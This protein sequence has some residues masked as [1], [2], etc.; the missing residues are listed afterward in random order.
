VDSGRGQGMAFR[1]GA[2]TV[3]LEAATILR[4]GTVRKLTPMEVRL[5]AYLSSRPGRIVP[6]QELLEQVWGYRPGVQTRT[7]DATVSRVREKLE[8]E[9]S[10]PEHL[11][12]VYG[13]GIKLAGVMAERDVRPRPVG[14]FFGRQHER[15][16]LVAA[17]SSAEGPVTVTGPPGAGKSR[18]AREVA[19]LLPLR[20]VTASLAA[21]RTGHDVDA[22]VASALQLAGVGDPEKLLPSA[23]AEQ[24]PL[25]L[26]LD[27]CERVAKALASRVERWRDCAPQ[28][29]VLAT[30]R[31]PL[32]A[33]GEVQLLLGGLQEPA[34]AEMFTARARLVAPSFQ[35][36]PE[37][38]RLLSLLDRL[39]LAIELAAARAGLMSV[40]ELAALIEREGGLDPGVLELLSPDEHALLA[41][42][43]V[44]EAPFSLEA[45]VVVADLAPAAVLD[46]L[47]RLVEF[48]LVKVIPADELGADE[49]R[50][51]PY[52]FVRELL[53]RRLPPGAPAWARHA[54]YFAAMG[55]PEHLEACGL[56]PRLRTTLRLAV[57]EL[58]AAQARTEVALGCGWA[59]LWHMGREGPLGEGLALS[60]RL[61][62][63]G[64]GDQHQVRWAHARGALLKYTGDYAG[65]LQVT[66]EAVHL[67]SDPRDI[68]ALRTMRSA[69]RGG[70]GDHEGALHEIQQA[71]PHAERSGLWYGRYLYHA[72]ARAPDPEAALLEAARTLSASGDVLGEA[73]CYGVLA[74]KELYEASWA[75]ADVHLERSLMLLA[76]DPSLVHARS[77][78]LTTAGMLEA[79]RGDVALAQARLEEA[80]RLQR[81]MGNHETL[82]LTRI[83]QARLQRAAGLAGPALEGLRALLAELGTHPARARA[84]LAM[85]ETELVSGHLGRAHQAA[86]HALTD[87]RATGWTVTAA[88][89]LGVLAVLDAHQGELGTARA[90]LQQ[91]L[92]LGDFPVCKVRFSALQAWVEALAGNPDAATFLRPAYALAARLEMVDGSTEL[93]WVRLVERVLAR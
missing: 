61:Q 7:L 66:E 57:P 63:L 13:Q 30:S 84:Y 22:A 77:V 44:F 58:R 42:L 74:S 3:D 55:S 62:T 33:A 79:R 67:A 75:A 90:R 40:P 16:T 28:V 51:T 41:D 27:E 72:A 68:V 39:P 82:S 18:L 73:S 54:R 78:T 47:Q 89:A 15:A 81:L 52:T 26:I 80:A 23:L 60:Q 4:Q 6:R 85:A 92:E 69:C 11:L 37:L 45:A 91:S 34:A 17:L 9:P 32:R 35:G 88:E 53:R 49:T 65:T 86:D 8:A 59:L 38:G 48:G 1:L 5:L 36:G 43:T 56:D 71:A 14:P 93:A 2:A 87:A 25:L 21:A 46:G 70:L 83:E 29:V 20:S 24:G 10:S 50:Y 31:A 19:A 12:V 64:E 76:S